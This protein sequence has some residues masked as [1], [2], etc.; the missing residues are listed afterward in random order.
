MKE[1]VGEKWHRESVEQ[2]KWEGVIIFLALAAAFVI[3]VAVGAFVHEARAADIPDDPQSYE[4]KV[5]PK[6]ITNNRVV[7]EQRQAM[8]LPMVQS[9]A[10]SCISDIWATISP[11]PEPEP[12]YYYEEYYDADYGYFEGYSASEYKN[13][14]RS[15]GIVHDDDGQTYSWYSQRK[16]PGG[17][18]TELNNNGRHVGDNGFIYDG[19]GYLAA[20]SPYGEE[21][22]TVVDTP[23]GQGKIYDQNKDGGSYDMYTDF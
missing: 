6:D 10:E 15:A 21:V 2:G 9:T 16:L 8:L 5:S 7:L 22:G 13:S 19:D 11:E 1:T 3:F 20:A 17:G 4:F 12:E 18:L 14:F 23:W